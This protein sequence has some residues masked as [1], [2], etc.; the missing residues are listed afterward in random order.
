MLKF[1]NYEN[2]VNVL[3]RATISLSFVVQVSS[4]MKMVLSG[5][6]DFT[7]YR[8]PFAHSETRGEKEWYWFSFNNYLC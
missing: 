1:E 6:Q 8:V 3:P 4:A 2:I 5:K 7:A